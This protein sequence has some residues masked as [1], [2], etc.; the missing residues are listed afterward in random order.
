MT[1]PDRTGQTWRDS[2]VLFLVLAPPYAA[3]GIVYH[4]VLIL[5]SETDFWQPGATDEWPEETVDFARWERQLERI[6]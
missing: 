6:A 3:S 4:R 5:S 1:P 2:G